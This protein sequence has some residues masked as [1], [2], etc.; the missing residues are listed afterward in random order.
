MPEVALVIIDECAG[1]ELNIEQLAER[2]RVELLSDGVREL[3]LVQHDDPA[4]SSERPGLAILRIAHAPCA[5]GSASFSVRIDDFVTQKR[6]ERTF[7][8]EETDPRARPRALALS[9]AELLR[10]SWAELA[11]AEPNADVPEAAL[12]SIAMRVR[13]RGLREAHR[14]APPLTEQD[15][16]VESAAP[17]ERSPSTSI[18][19]AFVARA[20]PSAAIAPMGGR[21]SLDL[22]PLRSFVIRIDLEAAAATSFDDPLGTIELGLATGGLTLAYSIPVGSELLLSIGPRAA[23]GA[24]W[25]NGSAR[26]PSTI[27]NSGAAPVITAGA[28]IE[29]D[30][31]LFDAFSAQFGLDVQAT[32]LSFEARVASVPVTG[33]AGASIGVW[34][35]LALAP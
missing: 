20:F 5:E 15:A 34:A 32:L 11:I 28:A 4:L 1:A 10:A 18:S 35:G 8:L 13:V 3:R 27:T 24:A 25:A 29:L 22:A 21:A 30:I 19:A 12:T 23:A 9:T 26:D 6:I 16:P 7:D 17:T 31:R 33:I 2:I 14:L